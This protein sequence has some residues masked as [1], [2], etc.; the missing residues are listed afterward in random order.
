MKRFFILVL[1]MAAFVSAGILS[2]QEHGGPVIEVKED[3]YDF[4][5]V[6]EGTQAVHVF[7][8]RNVGTEPLVIEKVQSS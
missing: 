6:V 8:F 4:G 2:A 5:K 3:K 1:T 7:D